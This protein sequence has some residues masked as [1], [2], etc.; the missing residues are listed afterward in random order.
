MKKTICQIIN[1]TI[2]LTDN[3]QIISNLLLIKERAE[4]MEDRLL[5]YCN[6]IEDLGFLRIGR[7]YDKQ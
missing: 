5:K 6:T 1:E 7:D 3:E 4:H 2:E